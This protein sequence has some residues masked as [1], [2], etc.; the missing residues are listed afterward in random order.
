MIPKGLSDDHF[1]RA[2][3]EIDLRG[4]APGRASRHYDLIL[5]GKSYPPKYIISLANRFAHG[6]DLPAEKFN[7]V[8]A[9]EYFLRS[10]Y[11]VL[12]RRRQARKFVAS[13]DEESAFPEGRECF[14]KHRHLER[15]NV[16]TRKAKERRLAALGR[17]ECDVCGFNFQ[18]TYG[19]L[20]RGFIEAHHL[21][22]VA[23]L[24]G[25]TKTKITEF[26]LVCSNCHRMLHRGPA[27]L[28]I[29]VLK[30]VIRG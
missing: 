10:G 29:A 13:Q 20:G 15:D 9:K 8:E 19:D 4:V 17:L 21:T 28:S 27:L 26:G 24:K 12:D 1:R 30:R 2:A 7:A 11:K 16:I 23:K 25:K 22:P 18:S 5:N 14:K 6:N 3:S